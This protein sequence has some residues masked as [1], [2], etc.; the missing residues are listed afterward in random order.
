M[1]AFKRFLTF[2]PVRDEICKI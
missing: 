2:G 1:T